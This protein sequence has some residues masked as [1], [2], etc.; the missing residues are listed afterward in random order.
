MRFLPALCLSIVASAAQGEDYKMGHSHLGEP[1][2]QGPRQK[3]WIMEGIG[4]VHLP[5]TTKNPE[6]QKW[7]DQGVTLLHSFWDYEAER[8]FRWCLKLEPENAMAYW[9]MARATSD[10][11]SAEFIKEA[12]KRKHTVTQ[13]ERLYIESMEALVANDALRD[14]GDDYRQRNR[15]HKRL[16]ESI[17]VR[18]PED[19]E[20]KALIALANMG[21]SRYGTELIVREI[22]AKLP[23]HPGAHHYRIHNWNYHEPEQALASCRRFG[24]IAAGVGHALHMPGH[25]YAQS[26][27]W[28]EAAI[29]MDSATRAE[30]RYM[31]ERLTFP[32]N[33]WNYGH[34]RAY[35]SYIQEQLGMANAALFGARQLIDAPLDPDHN[36]DLPYSSHSQGINAT[37][38]AAVKFERWNDLLSPKT[39]PWRDIFIDRMNKAYA[40]SRAHL[41]LGKLD[42]AEKSIEEHAALK[43]DLE[44]NKT[45]EGTFQIQAAELKARLAL[46]R[47]ETLQGLAMLADAAQKHFEMQKGDNDP[48]RYP[49]VL[50]NSLGRAYLEAQSPQ[51]ALK[52]FEK[53]LQLTRNDIFALS[54]LVEAHHALGQKKEAEEML[55]RLLFTAS[56]ADNGLAV[57]QRARATGVKAQPLDNAPDKQRTYH[58]VQLTQH[59]PNVWEPYGAPSLEAVDS[60][61]KTVTLSEYRGRNV[62]LVFYLGRECLHC[63]KQLK[64]INAKKA[65]WD[66]LDTVVLAVSSNRPQDNAA[67]RKAINLPAV[68][69]LSDTGFQNARRYK[70]Y[71][72]F[73]EMELHS[74]I[75]IDKK[76]RVHW[77]RNGG[78]PF[79]K[80]DFLI[81]QLERMNKFIETE[82]SRTATGGGQ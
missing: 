4:S 3:P 54:G 43:K 27:M 74:T 23:D 33:N 24:Q 45:H 5:I 10:K 51:L 64:D 6:V 9:G 52:A 41:G 58:E 71:D 42:K 12:A 73:E 15:E 39:I 20:A 59:G 13:R 30:K 50:Y 21:D 7:F 19:M 17:C 55:A 69:L 36:A 49:E 61:G 2:D 72:D 47:G 14:R 63:M 8:S 16:L 26:G 66:T 70:S 28:H 68:R 62:L 75:L 65:E 34:N 40:E 82:G 22:L 1:F 37:L 48:P 77:G 76:G 44:K 79:S 67:N 18:Y 56:G 29:S 46:A 35:L 25:V 60:E 57:V 78:E 31:I 81:K 32:F 11:R 80:M 38:R 53:G